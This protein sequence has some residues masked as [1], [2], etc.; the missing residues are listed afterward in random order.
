MSDSSQSV[1]SLQAAVNRLKHELATMKVDDQIPG[2]SATVTIADYLLERL[3]QLKV[4]V[5]RPFSRSAIRQWLSNVQDIF[6]V[7]GDF[8]LGTNFICYL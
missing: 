2:A 5:S 4:T 7:P 1:A 8:N 3:V 6:G